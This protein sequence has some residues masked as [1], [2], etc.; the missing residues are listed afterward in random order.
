[1]LILEQSFATLS[2]RPSMKKACS[3]LGSSAGVAS[4]SGSVSITIDANSTSQNL[5]KN[6]SRTMKPKKTI[7]FR[8]KI[9]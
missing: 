8:G 2:V 5:S 9:K 3:I 1:M 7:S 4:S 6:K